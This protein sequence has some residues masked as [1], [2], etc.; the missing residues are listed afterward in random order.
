MRSSQ[1]GRPVLPVGAVGDGGSLVVF[2][3]LPQGLFDGVPLTLWRTLSR[4]QQA[5][6]MPPSA[7]MPSGSS[8]SRLEMVAVIH[9]PWVTSISVVGVLSE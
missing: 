8:S 6:R 7:F 5:L 3:Q 4:H 1:I 9:E 2:L